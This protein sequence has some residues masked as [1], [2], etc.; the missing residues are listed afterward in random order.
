MWFEG[1]ENISLG[2][3]DYYI[4]LGEIYYY[5]TDK[6]TIGKSIFLGTKRDIY[7][8]NTGI[9]Y[10]NYKDCRAALDE[11]KKKFV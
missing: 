7:R 3:P 1:M 2:V 6:G 8:I 11:I 5:I 4:Y 10:F 9:T